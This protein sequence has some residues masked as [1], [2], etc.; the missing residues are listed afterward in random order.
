MSGLGAPSLPATGFGTR[1]FDYDNDGWLDILAVNGAVA[2][3][4]ALGLTA[5]GSDAEEPAGSDATGTDGADG[6][7]AR[8]TVTVGYGGTYTVR[9]NSLAAGERLVLT[10]CF[11]RETT[12]TN[13][14]GPQNQVQFGAARDVLHALH[15]S[16]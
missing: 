7:D 11:N 2:A 5:C 9:A 14:S 4:A 10:L 6:T 13:Q 3:L 16:D 1:F 12:V 15:P 8:L